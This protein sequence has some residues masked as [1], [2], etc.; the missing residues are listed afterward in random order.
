M[1]KRLTQL[2]FFFAFF[3][4]AVAAQPA[5]A[6]TGEAI[7]VRVIPNPERLSPSAWYRAN[8]PNPG[9]AVPL[10]VDGYPAVRD[11]RTVYV[12]GTNY[13]AAT[14]TLYSNVYLISHS[15]TTREDVKAVFDEFLRQFRLNTNIKDATVRAQMRRDMRRANDINTIKVLLVDYQKKTGRYP[16]FE[17]GSYL[18]HTTYSTWPSWQT[19]L[20]NL[21]GKAL[22]VDPRNEFIGCKDP[23]NA[24]TCWSES[25]RQFACP[26]EAFVYGYRAGD[27]GA[28]YALFTNFEYT[29]PGTWQ[30]ITILQQSSDQCFNFNAGD[31]TDTDADG[32]AMAIDN[33]PVVNNAGQEDTDGDKVGNAC[34]ACPA[35]PLNDQDN[36]GVCGNTDNCP[37]VA[38]PDQT[39]VDGDGIGDACDYQTCGNNLTEGTEVCDTLSGVSEFQRC[40]PDCRS[41][42]GVA[43]C[44]DKVVQTPNEQGITEE[45]DGN[46]ETE[47]CPDPINGYKAQRIRVCRNTCRFTPFTACTPLEVC[48]DGVING[49]EQ[50]DDKEKNGVQC[51]AAYGQ[52]CEYCNKVC[53]VKT[54]QG[55]RCGDGIAQKDL[56]EQCDE[57]QNNGRRCVP[58]YG[59]SCSFCDSSCKV[60]VVQGPFCGNG[61]RDLP[62]EECDAGQ[63]VDTPC[64]PEPTYFYKRRD[65][66]VQPTAQNRACTWGAYEACRQVGS[67]GDGIVNGP[68]KCDDAKT[69]GICVSCQR[70]NTVAMVNYTVTSRR[71]NHTYCLGSK[72]DW[73]GDGITCDWNTAG[74]DAVISRPWNGGPAEWWQRTW[75][76]PLPMIVNK[77]THHDW[78]CGSKTRALYLGGTE[79]YFDAYWMRAGMHCDGSDNIIISTDIANITADKVGI[80]PGAGGYLTGKISFSWNKNISTNEGIVVLEQ[81]STRRWLGNGGLPADSYDLTVSGNNALVWFGNT[82]QTEYGAG[83]LSTSSNTTYVLA[84]IDVNSNRKCDFLE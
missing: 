75:N 17:A 24:R 28:A 6:Q 61:A 52:T 43:Y 41:I 58:S 36:D 67:C 79:K 9:N 82:T 44:G 30:N 15:D 62:F 53:K 1:M 60:E 7:G 32:V 74:D 72:P 40:A 22:P 46:N 83:T 81:L 39:D 51:E 35:D 3:L 70:A 4:V 73:W 38:N 20:G 48:G 55:P 16:L 78:S 14:K 54:A 68:E 56:G 47:V 19:S 45:C 57:S 27:S 59:R 76:L 64:E 34:D 26:A 63:F 42:E 33:C 69:P 71:A 29:G 31:T 10:E 21:L 50:C 18:P 80:T 65:C 13:D 25:V 23:Y 5:S 2:F 66:V 77:I 49:F 8:V 12:S 84:C 11:G 37:T